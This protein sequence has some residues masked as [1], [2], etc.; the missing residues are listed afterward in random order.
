MEL[1]DTALPDRRRVDSGSPWEAR[2]GYS[3]AL[4]VGSRVL[5]TGTMAA[6]DGGTIAHPRDAEGQ[7]RFV[8]EKIGRALAACGAGFEH[9]VQTRMYVVD[10]DD[11]EAVGRAHHAVF[12]DIRPCA[13][14][15]A[16]SA[17][18]SPDAL[19]EIE[20]EAVLPQN[21]GRDASESA[22]HPIH[23]VD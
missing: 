4:V 6:Q 15:V 3:R 13:T 14:M 16:V 1:H 7:T 19:V 11:Q 10:I 5:V 17:L 2:V 21:V 8:L 18:A 12:G 23:G 22:D 20:A 9:V